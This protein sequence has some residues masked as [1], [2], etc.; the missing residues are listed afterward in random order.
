MDFEDIR[1]QG[2]RE[3]CAKRKALRHPLTVI[4]CHPETYVPTVEGRVDQELASTVT[5]GLTVKT[6]FTEDNLIRLRG[7][8]KELL[9]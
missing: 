1:T 5:Y 4:N 3:K 9:D 2:E 6:M 7:I 8:I